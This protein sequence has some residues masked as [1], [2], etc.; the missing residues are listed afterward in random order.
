M[1]PS[2]ILQALAQMTEAELHEMLAQARKRLERARVEVEQIEEALALLSRPVQ[3]GRTG[4]TRE[5]ILEFIAEHG[6]VAPKQV[7]EFMESDDD[8]SSATIYNALSRMVRANELIRGENGYEAPPIRPG[9]SIPGEITSTV[10]QL[11][12]ASLAARRRSGTR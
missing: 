12:A 7:I 9:Q 3:R 10:E 8:A 2:M 6:P 5:R 1:E 11:V 4:Q